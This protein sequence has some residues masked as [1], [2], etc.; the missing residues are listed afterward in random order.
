M[1]FVIVVLLFSLGYILSIKKNIEK[2]QHL[3]ART[4][5]NNEIFLKWNRTESSDKGQQTVS[6]K[7]LNEVTRVVFLSLNEWGIPF[8]WTEGFIRQSS[9]HITIEIV[10][11]ERWMIQNPLK[12]I[13][14]LRF[15]NMVR[16]NKLDLVLTIEDLFLDYFNEDN[17]TNCRKVSIKLEEDW[18]RGFVSK[19]VLEEML[20]SILAYSFSNNPGESV[21][22]VDSP[23]VEESWLQ[24][25][26]N[27]ASFIK[28]ANKYRFTVPNGSAV[29][30]SPGVSVAMIDARKTIVSTPFFYQSTIA[31][32][33]SSLR[34]NLKFILKNS[35]SIYPR[36]LVDRPAEIVEIG[37]DGLLVS[38]GECNVT[39]NPIS[40]YS[41][42]GAPAQYEKALIVSYKKKQ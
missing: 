22:F 8:N 25:E 1:I 4:V 18:S 37:E 9:R 33:L 11:P 27:G 12:P 21:S 19:G 3:S 40:S 38:K 42:S 16:S 23:S 28:I 15:F 17:P 7:I 14:P 36:K 10:K 6:S 30:T 5:L 29:K 35:L 41:D 31:Q 20:I 39:I 13:V 24:K 26:D 32:P 2:S 34:E